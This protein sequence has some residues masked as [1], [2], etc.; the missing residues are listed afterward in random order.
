MNNSFHRSVDKV[1]ES[2]GGY[3]NLP[4]DPGGETK[5][6][7]TKEVAKEHGYR[8]EME[9]LPR[10]KAVEIYYEDYWE[11]NRLGE[12][13]ELNEGVAFEIFDASV[14]LGT[15]TAVKLFQRSLNVFNKK[16][17][18]Y[19]DIKVDGI[20]GDNT[21]TAFRSF[22][23][24]RRQPAGCD[25]LRKSILGQKASL[26]VRLAEDNEELETFVYG[27]IANRT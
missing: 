6:G 26:Y 22:H 15:V 12:I 11:K 19:D 4:S 1:I 5:Y 17:E 16:G 9:D 24:S 3:I 27:W 25:V 21:I 20:I 23:S 2:E 18:A 8:N 10:S 13:A 7:I 14:H